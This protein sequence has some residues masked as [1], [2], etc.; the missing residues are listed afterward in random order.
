MR[1]ELWGY[2]LF[3]QN[4]DISERFSH[5]LFKVLETR[6]FFSFSIFKISQMPTWLMKELLSSRHGIF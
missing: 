3:V 2:V 4:Q 5:P 6:D 1:M